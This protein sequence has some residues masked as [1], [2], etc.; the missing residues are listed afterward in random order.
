MGIDRWSRGGGGREGGREGGGEGGGGS[1]DDEMGGQLMPCLGEG[2][3]A[4]G[5]YCISNGRLEPLE[6]SIKTDST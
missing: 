4:L 1:V 2:L 5:G 3:F 6:L